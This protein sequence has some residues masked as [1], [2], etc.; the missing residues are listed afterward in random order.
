MAALKHGIIQTWHHPN[1]TVNPHEDG[2]PLATPK[3]M[4]YEKHTGDT[5][6]V[7]Q[8]QATGEY[9]QNHFLQMFFI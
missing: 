2:L 9:V 7:D 8:E 3:G 5:G 6:R 4:K 1:M